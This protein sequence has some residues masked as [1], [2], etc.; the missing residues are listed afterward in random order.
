MAGEEHHRRLERMYRGAPVN[1]WYDPEI[2]IGDGAAEIRIRVREEFTHPVGGVHGSVYFK[3]L[4]DAAYFAV[5]SR[6]EETFI[7]TASFTVHFLAPVSSGEIRA[8]GRILH[9]AGRSFLAEAEL[10]DGDGRLVGHGVGTFLPGRT[11]LEEVEGY[12]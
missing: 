7:L 9:R 5:S 6:V 2:R 10:R 11:P 8:E 1:R 4:D 3:A 12:G